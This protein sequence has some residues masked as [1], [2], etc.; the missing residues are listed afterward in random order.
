MAK[1]VIT[2]IPGRPEHPGSSILSPAI[3]AGDFIFLSARGGG[4]G[5]KGYS[6]D[7]IEE[8]TRNCM[9]KIKAT[10][11]AAGSSLEDVVRMVIV[12]K[13]LDDE[14]KLYEILR[15]YFPKD[16]PVHTT[17]VGSTIHGF[18]RGALIE[19]ECTAYCPSNRGSSVA[20]QV[21]NEIPGRPLHPDHE[22]YSMIVRAGD[23][24]FLSPRQGSRRNAQGK[25]VEGGIEAPTKDCL[26]RVKTTLQAAGATLEDVVRV[27]II[28]KNPDDA[29]K[30][31]E[32]FRSYFPKDPPVRTTHIGNTIHGIKEGMLIEIEC[33]AYCPQ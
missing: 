12:L 15:G 22:K 3:K 18:S 19:M 27:V 21:I 5:G 4:G 10:L 7:G 2:K 31:N 29:D 9:E 23:F 8:K 13:D 20:K 17:H 33:T 26:E 6:S 14:D 32:V 16:P 25:I 28:L 1:Q 11:Q 24:L 30:M